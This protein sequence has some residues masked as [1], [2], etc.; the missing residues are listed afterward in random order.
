M[1]CY[2]PLFAYSSRFLHH[3]LCLSH[4]LICSMYAICECVNVCCILSVYF[5]ILILLRSL[6]EHNIAHTHTHIS[7]CLSTKTIKYLVYKCEHPYSLLFIQYL[8]NFFAILALDFYIVA[9]NLR[10]RVP[11]QPR[12]KMKYIVSVFIAWPM[13]ENVDGNEK[14]TSSYAKTST[15][16]R[17]SQDRD[18][19]E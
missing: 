15:H 17:R 11:F 14:Q 3:S 9:L 1:L 10:V 5:N 4:P 8:C 7:C 13:Q 19:E 2:V 6:N 16:Q 12:I 18:S